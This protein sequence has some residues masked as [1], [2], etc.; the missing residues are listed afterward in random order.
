M[1]GGADGSGVVSDEGLLPPGSLPRGFAGG[2]PAP[3]TPG[4][5]MLWHLWS[6][7][8]FPLLPRVPASKNDRSREGKI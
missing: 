3:R 5:G 6:F 2:G 7:N 1:A 4:C 8:P